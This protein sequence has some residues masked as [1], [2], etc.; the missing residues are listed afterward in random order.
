MDGTQMTRMVMIDYDLKDEPQRTQRRRKEHKGENNRTLMTPMVMIYTDFFNI[1]IRENPRC[2]AS[3]YAFFCH[4]REG[5]APAEA[6]AGK[7]AILN[8]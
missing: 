8:N 4:P 2:G 1:K 7:R 6:G 3:E 5:P